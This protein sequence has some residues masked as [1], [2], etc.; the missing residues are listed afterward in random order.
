MD[1]AK[2]FKKNSGDNSS[3]QGAVNATEG[4][5]NGNDDN[6]GNGAT[7]T[8]GSEASV[9]TESIIPI[10]L[11]WPSETDTLKIILP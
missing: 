2:H 7:K 3:K 4:N 8:S 11:D 9:L 6:S 1:A 5:G 10:Q